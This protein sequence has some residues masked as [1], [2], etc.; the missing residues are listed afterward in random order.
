MNLP[1]LQPG[2]STHVHVDLL[3]CL[4]PLGRTG[5]VRHTVMDADVSPAWD[6][7]CTL[8]WTL[9]DGNDLVCFSYHAVEV[10]LS[11]ICTV[12]CR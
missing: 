12:D 11:L 7:P 10:V 3:P 6:Q 1:F 9:V 2:Q 8:V 5:T 4:V